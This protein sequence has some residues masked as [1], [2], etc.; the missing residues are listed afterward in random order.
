MAHR[1]AVLVSGGQIWG[2][3]N[4]E[5]NTKPSGCLF[6]F[7]FTSPQHSRARIGKKPEDKGPCS[8]KLSDYHWFSWLSCPCPNRGNKLWWNT[9]LS[10]L[11][12]PRN[13]DRICSP[14]TFPDCE[15]HLKGLGRIVTHIK[16]KDLLGIAVR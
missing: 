7:F 11:R 1:R 13:P 12:S 6:V 10:H 15:L 14:R 4:N 3:A 8:S 16:D 5:R 2:Y 9:E